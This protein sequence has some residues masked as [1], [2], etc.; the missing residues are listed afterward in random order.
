M[1]KENRTNKQMEL[2]VNVERVY[3]IPSIG[4]VVQ[5][6]TIQSGEIRLGDYIRFPTFAPAAHLRFKV[7]EI[8]KHYD[9]IYRSATVGERVGL[10][11]G[12]PKGFSW[13][14][15]EGLENQPVVICP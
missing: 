8:L 15:L 5:L 14:L 2:C 3:R 1:C 9:I 13:K 12:V 7:K 6:E 10:Y 4:C 11:L